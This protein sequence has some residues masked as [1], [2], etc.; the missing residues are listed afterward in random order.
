M[1]RPPVF[2]LFLWPFIDWIFIK[3]HHI[4]LLAGGSSIMSIEIRH[5]KG[6]AITLA[7]RS[8]IKP[9]DTILE[10]HLN[11]KWFKQ[12]RQSTTDTHHLIHESFTHFIEDLNI[13][14]G[15]IQSGILPD[16][17]AIH[18]NTHL[19]IAASR[20]GFQV[21]ALPDTTWRKWAQFY[22]AGL[23]QVYGPRQTRSYRFPEIKE[24]WLSKSELIRKYPGRPPLM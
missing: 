6:Q 10:V 24:V 13:L 1:R 11:N 22:L 4:E 7:D 15:Q 5:Y 9:G 8:E 20:M 16:V 14:S 23:I 21:F 12:K 17:T 19:G 3:I 18:G 2:V